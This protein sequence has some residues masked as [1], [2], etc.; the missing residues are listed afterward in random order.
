MSG[1]TDERTSKRAS[2]R[3]NERTRGHVRLYLFNL[4]RCV[5]VRTRS[6]RVFLPL[7]HPLS[8]PPRL[9]YPSQTDEAKKSARGQIDPTARMARRE[10]SSVISSLRVEGEPGRV[11]FTQ[12]YAMSYRRQTAVRI[13]SVISSCISRQVSVFQE[14]TD[15]GDVL[16]KRAR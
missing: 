8:T 5:V 3:M 16:R 4:Y 15:K 14:V 2:E 10:R 6:S 1:R 13:T 12:R 7:S 11:E 9:V